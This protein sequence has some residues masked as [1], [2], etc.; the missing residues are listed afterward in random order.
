MMLR[1]TIVLLAILLV[2]SSILLH[3]NESQA[4]GWKWVERLPV[5]QFS[6]EDTAIFHTHVDQA[7]EEAQDGER[8]EWSNPDSGSSGAITPLTSERLNGKLCRQTRFEN[9]VD[10]DQ[11]ITEFL[12]CQQPDGSW[13]IES[14]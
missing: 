6:P 12:L 9:Q 11:N 2:T 10:Q 3:S 13:S 1:K 14:R 7:L 8:V 4:R 5:S